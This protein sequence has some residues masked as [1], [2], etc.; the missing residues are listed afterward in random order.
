MP[1]LELAP[2]RQTGSTLSLERVVSL[3]GSHLAG[4]AS[5]SRSP[6]DEVCCSVEMLKL[7]INALGG[8]LARED[9][10]SLLLK[11]ID[12]PAL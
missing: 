8:L 4:E 5:T 9:C 1:L 6:R 3:T 11:N 2:P 10:N 7:L 12:T